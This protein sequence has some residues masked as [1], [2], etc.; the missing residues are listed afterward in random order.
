MGTER[1]VSVPGWV[2]LSQGRKVSA[3]RSPQSVVVSN[4]LEDFEFLKDDLF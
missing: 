4:N 3:R 2:L 1:G